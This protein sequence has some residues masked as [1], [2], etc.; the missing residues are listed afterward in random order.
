LHARA[1]GNLFEL[2]QSELLAYRE[3]L[4]VAH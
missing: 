1:N 2:Y 3:L 4:I